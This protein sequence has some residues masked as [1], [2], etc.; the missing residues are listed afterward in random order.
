MGAT[1]IAHIYSILVA[2]KPH[3]VRN[4]QKL[5]KMLKNGQNLHKTCQSLHGLEQICAICDSPKSDLKLLALIFYVFSEK[6]QKNVIHP[7]GYQL[8]CH[9]GFFV[10]KK[11]KKRKK[12]LF[13][14]L[15]W[16]N[17]RYNRAKFMGKKW[18]FWALRNDATFNSSK[19]TSQTLIYFCQILTFGGG[20]YQAS[21]GTN[22]LGWSLELLFRAKHGQI[23]QKNM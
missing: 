4:D 9:F 8:E 18:P 16:C 17:M 22:H 3:L 10:S 1:K 7:M 12:Q 20:T 13:L 2:A 19:K 5:P 6:S 23:R 14:A 21:E 15:F 11:R